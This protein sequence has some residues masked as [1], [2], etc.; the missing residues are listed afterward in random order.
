MRA[1]VFLLS[2]AVF[3]ATLVPAASA[4]SYSLFLRR[5]A[6]CQREHDGRLLDPGQRQ[7]WW[8]SLHHRRRIV[9]DAEQL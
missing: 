4:D 7:F 3:L 2:L 5:N 6:V 9:T 1:P 8:F